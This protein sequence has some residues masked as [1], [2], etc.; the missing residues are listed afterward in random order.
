MPFH[1]KHML[2]TDDITP[3]VILSQIPTG[4]ANSLLQVNLTSG[5]EHLIP[6]VMKSTAA[7]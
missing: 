1:N 2:A 3:A 7:K 4:L 6:N 5:I